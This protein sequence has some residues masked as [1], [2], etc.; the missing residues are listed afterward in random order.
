MISKCIASR[1]TYWSIC[2][3]NMSGICFK[4]TQESWW[5]EVGE[6]MKPDRSC[7]WTDC[8]GRVS[9]QAFLICCLTTYV[10]EGPSSLYDPVFV[11]PKCCLRNSHYQGPFSWI[12]I[13]LSVL[14]CMLL[15]FDISIYQRGSVQK[16]LDKSV[17]KEYQER[18]WT[19]TPKLKGNQEQT[20]RHRTVLWT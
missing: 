2:G 17:R 6:K 1:V 16:Q 8:P 13:K 19:V 20:S 14:F 3:K 12:K 5:K 7:M 11:L 9:Q 4:R 18:T 10:E 15:G